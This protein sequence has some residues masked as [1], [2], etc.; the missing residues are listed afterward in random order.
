MNLILASIAIL[1]YPELALPP[2]NCEDRVRVAIAL[3]QDGRRDNLD[4][5]TASWL[6]RMTRHKPTGNSSGPTPETGPAAEN[7]TLPPASAGKREAPQVI[8]RRIVP[9]YQQPLPYYQPMPY[10]PPQSFYQGASFG[11]AC[12]SGV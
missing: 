7:K 12:V 11:G 2:A 5:E 4:P 9:V 8:E 6:D 1:A 3:S 10:Y